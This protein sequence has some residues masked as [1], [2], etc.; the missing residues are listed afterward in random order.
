MWI[1]P[2]APAPADV[3]VTRGRK[4][5]GGLRLGILDNSKSNADHLLNM[6]VEGIKA[7]LP[8]SSIVSLR[9]PSPAAGADPK[10]LEQLAED[11][12]CVISAMAD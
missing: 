3:E 9:K 6:I 10:L 5:Q 7:H 11:A 1:I 12:D 4:V 2:E 8:V